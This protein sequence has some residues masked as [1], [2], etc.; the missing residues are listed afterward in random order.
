[1]HRCTGAVPDSGGVIRDFRFR[2]QLR[3]SAASAPSNIA[4]GFGRYEPAEFKALSSNREWLTRR[5]VKP[6]P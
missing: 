4:E 1:V 5:D 3:D 2:D 6:S